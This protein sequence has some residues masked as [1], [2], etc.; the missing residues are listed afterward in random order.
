MPK[1]TPLILLL[2]VFAFA[3]NVKAQGITDIEAIRVGSDRYNVEGFR[4]SD[5]SKSKWL[6]IVAFDQEVEQTSAEEEGNYVIVDL[7]TATFITP[8]EAR[9]FSTADNASVG[10]CIESDLTKPKDSLLLNQY[11]VRVKGIKFVDVEDKPGNATSLLV[12]PVEFRTN[13]D[14]P[15]AQP[16]PPEAIFEAA[17]KPEDSDIYASGELRRGSGTPFFGAIDA[18]IGYPIVRTET[19]VVKPFFELKAS[20]DPEDDPDTMKFG[21]K[22]DR[23][24]KDDINSVLLKVRL[25]NEGVVEA[26]RDF[27]TAN[28]RWGGG[29]TF[30][31]RRTRKWPW[32]DPFVGVELGRNVRSPLPA[33]EDRG[34]AR[35][36]FGSRLTKPWKFGFKN[37]DSL[38]LE[39]KYE[40]RVLLL[41]EISFE[42][43]DEQLLL[44][45]FGKRPRDWVEAKF[46]LNFKPWWGLYIGYE[47]GELPPA[48]KLIDHRMKTGIFFRAK[49]K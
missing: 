8:L 39:A 12:A 18:D 33:A 15:P 25:T 46:T 6:I 10:L 38:K 3:S 4:C 27:D 1:T 7:D 28:I 13:D 35:I 21:V 31:S 47:Y 9:M 24:L 44:V 49:F 19:N 40:R 14:R 43:K 20:A 23:I 34:L 41:R 22:W 5:E 30:I 11:Q 37:L 26:E 32:I 48:Y 45:D 42:E 2:L 17:D 16:A 29:F 36:V